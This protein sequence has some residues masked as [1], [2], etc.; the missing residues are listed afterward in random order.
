MSDNPPTLDELD[1]QDKK[2]REQSLEETRQAVAGVLDNKIGIERLL[3]IGDEEWATA[4]K[5]DQEM[6]G[7][8]A[9]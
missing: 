8:D 6:E 7:S 2:R 1:E 9:S 4:M 5:K 3:A